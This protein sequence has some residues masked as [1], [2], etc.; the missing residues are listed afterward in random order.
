MRRK[1]LCL[2]VVAAGLEVLLEVLFQPAR[3]KPDLLLTC[4]WLGQ[5]LLDEELQQLESEHQALGFTGAH[6]LEGREDVS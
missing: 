5:Y 2:E 3:Q 1:T 4:T 6:V